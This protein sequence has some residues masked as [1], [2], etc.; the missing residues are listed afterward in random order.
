MRWL[1]VHF[2]LWPHWMVQHLVCQP[3]TVQFTYPST[4]LSGLATGQN[5]LVTSFVV[6]PRPLLYPVL[7]HSL[8]FHFL[9]IKDH[10][11]SAKHFPLKL[12][13]LQNLLFILLE[14]SLK[15]RPLLFLNFSSKA[16]CKESN[17]EN[18][19]S[20]N[21]FLTIN[22]NNNWPSLNASCVWALSVVFPRVALTWS[23]VLKICY[24]Y[25]LSPS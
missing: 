22:N 21:H 18:N 17:P 3:S 9:G 13:S 1:Q 10:S 5:S 8:F 20:S 23:A 25:P 15:L 6:D 12:S 16:F 4:S 2:L 24:R 19:S 11:F 14:F 7:P